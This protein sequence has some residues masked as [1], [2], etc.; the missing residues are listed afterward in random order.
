ME[1]DNDASGATKP[2][3]K[4]FVWWD[5]D[6]AQ[7]FGNLQTPDGDTGRYANFPGTI[8]TWMHGWGKDRGVVVDITIAV[9]DMQI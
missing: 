8:V 5:D 3:I 4:G 9:G 6:R 7:W 1:T 2:R